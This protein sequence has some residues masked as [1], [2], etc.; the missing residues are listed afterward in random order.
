MSREP[1]DLRCLNN[2]KPSDEQ[3]SP[4]SH[5][6]QIRKGAGEADAAAE[7]I[8]ITGSLRARDLWSAFTNRTG[9]RDL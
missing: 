4:R 5:T 3:N 8:H 6:G 1:K 2:S 9:H 7:A